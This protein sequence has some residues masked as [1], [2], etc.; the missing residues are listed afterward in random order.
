VIGAL[1]RAYA[2]SSKLGEPD[3]DL[4]L[5]GLS[6]P[7]WA[8]H[9]FRRTSDKFARDCMEDTGATKEDIDEQ[10]GW[11]QAERAKDQQSSYAGP[12]SRSHRARITMMI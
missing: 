9:T 6:V 1:K 10:F 2:I 7:K 5:E 3:L 11:K 8:H 12:R 4:D